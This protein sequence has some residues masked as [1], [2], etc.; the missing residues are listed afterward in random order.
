MDRVEQ[1]KKDNFED[2]VQKFQEQIFQ[3]FRKM[4]QDQSGNLDIDE[5]AD[6]ADLLLRQREDYANMTT[7]DK[8]NMMDEIFQEMDL[9][10][11]GFV[12]Y[13][14]LKVYLTRKLIMQN[15]ASHTSH[16]TR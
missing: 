13:H 10:G 15:K 3:T 4:D 12:S 7:I 8:K 14:E 2:K 5:C 6:L 11:S 16:W 9:D 1:R